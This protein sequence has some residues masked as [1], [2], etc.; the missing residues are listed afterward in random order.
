MLG[1]K[2]KLHEKLLKFVQTFDCHKLVKPVL[3]NTIKSSEMFNMTK[4]DNRLYAFSLKIITD[5]PCEPQI[6][7][8]HLSKL[9]IT[10]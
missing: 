7:L 3:L 10:L 6:N 9:Q 5:T 8:S 4:T 2:E 1:P